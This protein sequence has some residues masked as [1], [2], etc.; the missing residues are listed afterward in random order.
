M[1]FAVQL[2]YGGTAVHYSPPS[3]TPPLAKKRGQAH[4][5]ASLLVNLWDERLICD[6][7]TASILKRRAGA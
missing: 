3:Q 7:L 5:I 4:S 1:T 6:V 2:D